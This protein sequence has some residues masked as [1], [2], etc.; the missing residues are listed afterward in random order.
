MNVFNCVLTLF[1]FMYMCVH[2]CVYLG[3]EQE[4]PFPIQHG[5]I[6]GRGLCLG[7]SPSPYASQ[8]LM[9]PI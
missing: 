2:E 5:C 4:C 3:G 7:A 9:V 6:R 1:V 8:P